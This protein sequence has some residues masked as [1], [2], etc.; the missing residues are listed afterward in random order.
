MS[1][2]N[3]FTALV[4]QHANRGSPNRRDLGGVRMCEL[5]HGLIGSACEQTAADSL[6]IALGMKEKRRMNWQPRRRC[7]A[8]SMIPFM[9]AERHLDTC[10][11]GGDGTGTFNIQYGHRLRCGGSWRSGGE[12]R[13]PRP[14][15]A[16]PAAL[17]CWP[18]LG[19]SVAGDAVGG[20]TGSAGHGFLLRAYAASGTA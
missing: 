18:R 7:C 5:M 10:G 6:L 2:P 4:Y 17:T 16:V 14:R 15:R 20:G 3:A 13:Q 1:A 11:T 9:P 19:V 12:T 8:D